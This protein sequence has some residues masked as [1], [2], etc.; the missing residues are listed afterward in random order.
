M[1][2]LSDTMEEGV[3]LKWLR[4][5][6]EEIKQGDILVEIQSDK[7]DMELEAYDTGVVRKIFVAEGGKAPIGGLIAVIGRPDEDI[8]AVL[9]DAPAAS[10]PKESDHSE[11][12][13][14]AYTPSFQT[15]AT[16]QSFGGRRK[17]SPLARRL[18]NEFKIDLSGVSG[19]G[20]QGRVIKRDLAGLLAGKRT[21][22][23]AFPRPSV[24]GSSDD[25]VSPLSARPLRTE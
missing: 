19:T 9:S 3:I 16:P 15:T 18:A 13:T 20:P 5:E 1:P 8:S 23:P 14:L 7:A 21:F 25:V 17:A 4:K 10:A 12:T 11:Q 2:K 24:P 22:V 6:G